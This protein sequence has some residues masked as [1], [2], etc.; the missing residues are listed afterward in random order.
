MAA[1]GFFGP[2][3]LLGSACSASC[4][5]IKKTEY[6][7]EDSSLTNWMLSTDA[8]QRDT[9][10]DQ[11]PDQLHGTGC[12]LGSFTFQSSGLWDFSPMLYV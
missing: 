3:A 7:L 9:E 2:S 11:Y 5:M 4:G 1:L 6:C 10:K 12:H 8:R